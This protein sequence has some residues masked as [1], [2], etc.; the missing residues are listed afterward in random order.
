MSRPFESLFKIRY[1]SSK[2]LAYS[3]I[4]ALISI[5]HTLINTKQ[6]EFLH[7]NHTHTHTHTHIY[8]YVCMYIYIWF[9]I[10]P[11]DPD[12][13][14]SSLIFPLIHI[15]EGKQAKPDA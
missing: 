1:S 15:W 11:K 13:E 2:G 10:K 9:E 7:K 8:M 12:S 3:D 6:V 5:F 14:I 4:L